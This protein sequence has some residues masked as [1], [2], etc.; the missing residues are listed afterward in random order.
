MEIV[1]SYIG[2]RITTMEF[3]AC[4]TLASSSADILVELI[5][6]IFFCCTSTNPKVTLLFRCSVTCGSK[7]FNSIDGQ[8][9]GEYVLAAATLDVFGVQIVADTLGKEVAMNQHVGDVIHLNVV[10]LGLSNR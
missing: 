5:L 8:I 6:A 10:S 7:A 1:V 2:V 4:S 9:F 3:V